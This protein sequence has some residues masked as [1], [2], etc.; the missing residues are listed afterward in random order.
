M[1]SKANQTLGKPEGK[2]EH[3]RQISIRNFDA[4]ICNKTDKTN[5]EIYKRFIPDI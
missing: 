1:P 4:N 3:Y 2:E 5:L